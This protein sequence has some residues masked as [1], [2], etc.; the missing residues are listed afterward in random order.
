MTQHMEQ[1]EAFAGQVVSDV[2]ATLSGVMTNIGHKLGLYKSMAGAGPM[3]ASTLAARAQ[4]DERYTREWL[5]NQVA[6][7]YVNYDTQTGHYE[8][9]DH[10][11][12]VLADEDSP[13]FLVPALEVAASLWLDEEKIMGVFKSGEGIAWGDHHHRLFCGSEA[14]FRPGYRTNLIPQW[15]SALDG[16]TQ[17]LSEGAR[18]ADIGCGHGAS[19][20]VLANAFA[21]SRFFGFDKHAGSVATAQE[22]AR[23]A[24]CADNIEFVV[25]DA[26]SYSETDFDLICFMDCL[27]DMGDP[28]GAA[29]TAKKALKKNGSLLLV[30]PAARDCVSDN[31]NPVSRMYYAASTA[32]CTPCSKSQEVGLAL[33]AQAGPRQLGEILAQA[34]FGNVRTVAETPF[35]IVLEARAS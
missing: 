31:I 22:R 24:Q 14:L 1:V 28:V 27:H 29:A 17:K 8:L 35:N 5:N 26:A 21:N 25:A 12:P 19:T 9:P 34:G 6:G 15:I 2:A 10:H 23:E 7:G 20:I 33:G 4:T 16:M 11:V 30:E 13:V 18:V 3:S 32:V